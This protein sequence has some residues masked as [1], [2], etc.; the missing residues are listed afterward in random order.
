MLSSSHNVEWFDLIFNY[1]IYVGRVIF[2]MSSDVFRDEYKNRMCLKIRTR[3]DVLSSP[4]D[5]PTETTLN[6]F[7]YFI[8]IQLW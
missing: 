8:I 6:R 2:T 7:L 1:L 3:L 4:K 5:V